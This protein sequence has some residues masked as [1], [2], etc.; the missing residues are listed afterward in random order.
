VPQLILAL[1][2]AGTSRDACLERYA[3]RAPAS[4]RVYFRAFDT[5]FSRVGEQR[6]VAPALLKA[7]AWCETRL[8]PCAVSPTG[9]R[10]LMQ[11]MPA[12]F[13]QVSPAASVDDPFNPVHAI[14]SAGVYVAALINYWHGSLEAVVASYN[15]GPTAVAK[16]LKRG[17]TVPAIAETQGYVACVLGTFA[18]LHDVTPAH[19]SDA[20]LFAELSNLISAPSPGDAR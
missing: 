16:A 2:V 15:A 1:M 10:G 14:E 17:R 6:G 18:R 3:H 19:R 13:A 11:F 20:S 12:T 7:I 5:V 9:A 8:D 4:G